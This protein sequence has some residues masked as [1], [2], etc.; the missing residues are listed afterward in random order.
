MRNFALGALI[1][2]VAA[3]P[4]THADT[5]SRTN[6]ITLCTLRAKP[7]NAFTFVRPALRPKR[8][9][10]A[11]DTG[12]TITATYVGFD[13]FPGAQAAFEFALDIWRASIGSPVP[14]TVQ[15]EF[16]ALDPGQLGSAGAA[17]SYVNSPGSIPMTFYGDP[18]ADRLATTDQRPGEF[19]I[20]ASFSNTT[21]WYFG[22]DGNTPAGKYDFVSVVL[23]ELGHGLEFAGSAY[24]F[25][26]GTNEIG[27][28]GAG[29][30]P[31]VY[32]LFA[33]TESGAPLLGF[34]ND[35]TELA[36]QLTRAYN[37][38][39]PRGPGVYWAGVNGTAANGGLTPR[40]Y[41]PATFLP[42]SSY[43]HLDED[44]YP[45][46]NPH[47]LMTFQLA[48]AEAIHDPGG[49]VLGMFDDMG[50]SGFPELVTNGDFSNGI[51]SWLVFEVPDIVH[52][53]ASSG[54][55]V[56]HKAS[57]TT[58]ASKQAVVFQ[59]TGA[60]FAAGEQMLATFEVGNT[61]NLRKRFSVLIHDQD[62]SDLSVCTFWLP[63]F[64]PRLQYQMLT[65]TTEAW[66][67]ATISIYAASPGAPGHDYELDNVSL[68]R[69]PTGVATETRCVDPWFALATD[70][71][72]SAELV[73]NGG[74]DGAL[75]PWLT[76]GTLT[77]QLSAGV[78]EFV[79]PTSTPPAGVVFQPTG[80]AV[81]VDTIVTA[82]FQLGNSSG[83]R[84]RVTVLLHDQDFSDLSACTFW[85]PPGQPLSNYAMRAYVTDAWG[86]ATL[87]V[88]AASVG[89]QQWSRLDNVSMML[90]PADQIFGTECAEPG[91]ALVAAATA[92]DAVVL[93]QGNAIRRTGQGSAAPGGHALASVAWPTRP[94]LQFTI[95]L[96]AHAGT[97]AVQVSNDGV[98][99][100]TVAF[101]PIVDGWANVELVDDAI[102]APPFFIRLL[103]ESDV[104][105]IVHA[106]K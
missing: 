17:L 81:P 1:V 52:N 70:D 35:S 43:S 79:R 7:G 14:I 32:D 66:T 4:P 74:F 11:L 92:T 9:I 73:S 72:D 95:R 59:N 21:E 49:V 45:E 80:Q 16:S 18:L 47:S 78:F 102:E 25:F 55:F 96:P 37:P 3:M 24:V 61:S 46:G 48:A 23:H 38:G 41:T 103:I 67:S 82:R 15:A 91:H 57:P 6:V 8:T 12:T 19:D 36:V 33:V 20:L 51:A 84:K 106:V 90:T 69:A 99:W 83:V 42:G 63:P 71:P 30:I 50:W 27:G 101:V 98:T 40:L 85:L 13:A 105:S 76:F 58:T 93:P 104:G 44:T 56:Y 26:D 29:G 22:T 62:F 89:T 60:T 86:N 75:T 34:P 87:S 53:S 10:A 2:L 77:H 94:T 100:R 68:K 88:Y 54:V 28:L 64:A 39:N 5:V 31:N 65:H 97:A